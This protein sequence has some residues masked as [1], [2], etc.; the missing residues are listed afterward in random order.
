MYSSGSKSLTRDRLNTLEKYAWLG[1]MLFSL[2]WMARLGRFVW[3]HSVDCLY[4]DAW[5]YTTPIFQ[6]KG[7]LAIFR[8]QHG[9]HREGIGLLFEWMALSLTRWNT[10]IVDLTMVG[11]VFLALLVAFAIRYRLA[12]RLTWWDLLLPLLFGNL[13]FWETLTVGSH[14]AHSVMPL[15]LVMLTGLVWILPESF[16]QKV[17][18]ILLNLCSV[19]TGFALFLAPY[20][21]LL[22]GR[23]CWKGKGA[24]ENRVAWISLAFLLLTDASFFLGYTFPMASTVGRIQPLV[25]LEFVTVLVAYFFKTRVWVGGVVLC[26]MIAACL[27]HG[28]RWIRQEKPESRLI[29]LLCGFTLL[30][31]FDCAYGRSVNGILGGR[32]SRYLMLL[33]PGMLGLYLAALSLPQTVWRSLSLVVL[34]LLAYTSRE[35]PVQEQMIMNTWLKGRADWVVYYKQTGSVARAEA[36]AHVLMNPHPEV[37]HMDEKLAYLKARQLNLFAP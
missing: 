31:A 4:M 35:L 13:G 17:A 32:T 15:L 33:L 22:M 16:R 3:T 37:S 9:P 20:N 8:W 14:V 24:P 7:L 10:K 30:F 11:L 21:A 34:L 2:G 6:G 26:A 19:Y 36:L 25:Y 27:Y 28:W 5:D 29:F 12:G 18:L 1:V 23:E